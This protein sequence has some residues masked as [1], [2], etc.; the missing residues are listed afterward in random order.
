[1]VA[2]Y[3]HDLTMPEYATGYR[4]DVVLTGSH[5]TWTETEEGTS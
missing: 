3:D 4:W 5:R 2:L 1:L